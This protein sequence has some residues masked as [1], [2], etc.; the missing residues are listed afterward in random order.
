MTQ[1]NRYNQ[2]KIY[3]IKDFWNKKVYIGSTVRDLESQMTMHIR[4][5]R[6][7][8][9]K[10]AISY[11]NPVF[12]VFE[13]FGFDNCEIELIELF[14]CNNLQELKTRLEYHILTKYCLNKPLL[15]RM[16]KYEFDKRIHEIE[17]Y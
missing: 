9:M 12:L 10:S 3:K 16:A 2:G 8:V 4:H 14:P 6:N 11:F 7:Y 17:V 15:I 5:F 1:E 13:E